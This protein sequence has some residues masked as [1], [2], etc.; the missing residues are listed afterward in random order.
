MTGPADRDD[1]E[2]ADEAAPRQ[3]VE[4][5]RGARRARLTPAPGTDPEPESAVPGAHDESEDGPPRT[6]RPED[7]RITRE[8]PPHW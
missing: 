5:S 8:R 7:D 1:G 6:S 3:R 4:R 2:Q